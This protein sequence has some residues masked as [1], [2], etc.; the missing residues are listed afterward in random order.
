MTR[1]EENLEILEE[2]YPGMIKLINDAKEKL[3]SELTVQEEQSNDDEVIL[4]VTKDDKTCYLT[5]KR[6][7]KEPAEIWVQTLGELVNHAPSFMV[8]TGNWTYLRT[9]AEQCKQS[10]VI[11]VYEP[12]LEIF[13]TFLKYANLKNWMKKH[14]IVF[15]I[16]GLDGMNERYLKRMLSGI[17][18]YE[19]K[20]Y[21]RWFMLPNYDQ[22]FPNQ[23]VSFFKIYRKVLVDEVVLYNTQNKF[24]AVMAKNLLA[25]ARY[26]CDGYKTT[27]LVEVIPRNIPGIVVAAGPSLNKNIKELKKAKGKAF[28]IAVD[29]AIKPLL[30]EG[31]I[32]DMYCAVDAMKPLDLVKVEEARTIPVIITLNVANDLVDYHIGK[33]FFFDEIY[34]FAE[35][36]FQRSGQEFG[37]VET[38]GSVATNAFS[39]LYK[40]GITTIIL[41]GQDL[42]FTNNK[43]HADGTFKEKMEE[44]DTSHFEMVEGNYEEKVPTR[45]DFKQ[46]LEWYA[47]YIK[48]CKEKDKNFRVINATEGGAKIEGTELMPLKDAIEEVC[49]QEVDIASC[50]DKLSPMLD[51]EARVWTIEYLKS[52]PKIYHQLILDARKARQLY[53]KLDQ[54]CTKKNIDSGEY[55]N[56]LRKIKKQVKKIEKE[57]MYQMIQMSMNQAQYIMAQEGYEQK[58]TV[59]EEGKE[60][61]RKGIL[62]TEN[63]E[64][65]AELLKEYTEELFGNWEP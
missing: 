43:S 29:T 30:K 50:L 56:V 22:L 31:I 55:L 19:N 44:E 47:Y 34:T 25:N 17:V 20:N 61:A 41:V 15:W 3:N 57:P 53:Q 39:L 23:V 64:E 63:V 65:C 37:T 54:V 49:H 8:G 28:I 2:Q 59:Q 36:I 18:R 33:K 14:T 10:L 26:L 51:K 45:P 5:G 21:S 4:K 27:Q 52:T 11:V 48:G 60:I 7:T 9:L 24:S 35:R 62:Y 16:D 32:P 46:Y 38:G 58:N 12:S 1:Y 40:I 42:A 6:N 13:L